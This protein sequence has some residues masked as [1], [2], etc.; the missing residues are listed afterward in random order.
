[1]FTVLTQSKGISGAY[2]DSLTLCK[3]YYYYYFFLTT[4]F[5]QIIRT[6]FSPAFEE[7]AKAHSPS[8]MPVF[9]YTLSNN[10]IEGR[11]WWKVVDKIHL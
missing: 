5:I 11:G 3:C 6:V 2:R 9:Q 7:Q 1:M 4:K 8:L 10:S